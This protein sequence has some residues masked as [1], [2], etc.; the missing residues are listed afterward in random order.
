MEKTST[1]IIIILLLIAGVLLV[2]A[3]K[4]TITSATIQESQKA[5]TKAICNESNFC[6]DYYIICQGEKLI[7][8][9]PITGATIQH[10]ENWTDPRNESSEELC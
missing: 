8:R 7:S 6:Q 4:N 2:I 1:T 10:S 5:Y 9:N 3:L